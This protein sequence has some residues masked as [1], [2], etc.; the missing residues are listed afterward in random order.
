[1]PAKAGSRSD[2]KARAVSKARAAAKVRPPRAA[3]NGRGSGRKLWGG[4]T[5][6]AVDNFPISG[7]VV[8]APVIHWLARI[9]GASAAVNAELGLLPKQT[10]ARIERA[11]KEI[12]S[13]QHDSQFP[14]DV[15][16][17]GSGTST[18]TNT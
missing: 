5:D 6:K 4:E 8:P 1:M 11:A 3:Q 16:Q 12:A 18:N 17:T 7:Q 14:I 9:K 15:F 10:A 13:G 2:G